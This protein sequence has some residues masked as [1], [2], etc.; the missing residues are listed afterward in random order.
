MKTGTDNTPLD[1]L[2]AAIKMTIASSIFLLMPSYLDTLSRQFDTPI[3]QLTY[4][5]TIELLGFALAPLLCFLA[6]KAKFTLKEN[7]AIMLLTTCHLGSVYCPSLE[8]FL[9]LRIGAGI[10][11]GILLVRAIEAMAHTQNPD[12]AFAKGIA[13]Q[14]AFSAI[15]FVLMPSLINALGIKAFYFALALLSGLLILLKRQPSVATTYQVQAPVVI[16]YR[17][18]LG[19]ILAIFMFMMAHSAAWSMLGILATSHQ[20]DLQQQGNILAAGTVFSLL[21][22]VLSAILSQQESHRRRWILVG[23]L[24]QGLSLFVLFNSP[25]QALYVIAVAS[26]MLLWNFILPLLMGAVAQADINGGAMRFVVA[27]Q[28]VGAAVGPSVVFRSWVLLELTVFLGIS[29]LLIYPLI[30]G[31][32]ASSDEVA[33]G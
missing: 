5:A 27:A 10:S 8:W 31:P 12:A 9:V 7:I 17:L 18:L 23:M 6:S 16:N 24:L 19:G 30:N 32:E 3:P 2:P 14:M 11:A 20:F 28:T 21:G 29:L 4:L 22:A 13:T 33:K 1:W 25:Q 26:F 15:M